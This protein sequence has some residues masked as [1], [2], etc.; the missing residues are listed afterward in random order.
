MGTPKTSSLGAAR[1]FLAAKQSGSVRRVRVTKSTKETHSTAAIIDQ[2]QMLVDTF[3]GVKLKWVL[4]SRQVGSVGNRV[5]QGPNSTVQHGDQYFELTFDKKHKEIVDKSYLPFVMNQAKSIKQE[6]KTLKLYTASSNG[7]LSGPW[8]LVNLDHPAT[9]QTLAMDLELKKKIL[10]DLDRFV[11]RKEYYR[12]VGKVWKRGYLL[13]GP[14]GTGKSSLVA[15][16]ANY[17][18]FDVYDLELSGLRS[19][20]NLRRLLVATTN[21]SILVVEDIDCTIQ[22]QDRNPGTRAAGMNPMLMCYQ[23]QDQVTLSRFLNFTDGLWLSCGNEQIIVFMTNHVEKLDPAILRPG[24]MDLHIPM[25]YCTPC[26]FRLLAY[27]YLGI[28][29]HELFNQI[30]SAITMARVTPA[31]VAEELMKC[32]ESEIVLRDMVSFLTNHKRKENEEVIKE[33]VCRSQLIVEIGGSEE[34]SSKG[35]A[36]GA[37]LREV[38]VGVDRG[39]SSGCGVDWRGRGSETGRGVDGVKKLGVKGVA[40]RSAR[41]GV[42]EARRLGERGGRTPALNSGVVGEGLEAS[43]TQQVAADRE[44]SGS[45]DVWLRRWS[46]GL[47]AK[48]NGVAGVGGELAGA[49]DVAASVLCGDEVAPG[50]GATSAGRSRPGCCGSSRTS[51]GLSEQLHGCGERR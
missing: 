2:N 6:K 20:A 36:R 21:Q 40:G 7:S 45:N 38:S 12:R 5:H 51:V 30:E 24:R 4:V 9:F 25:S 19:N 42:A 1:V 23:Q 29:H 43:E 41:S 48:R 22:L 27:N 14:P 35:P 16:M 8:S 49:G 28:D 3:H 10:D 37:A 18:N 26:G 11:R 44:S 17:L 34:E 33:N 32:D 15:A 47:K 39:W 13:Y 50:R 31:E 46:F